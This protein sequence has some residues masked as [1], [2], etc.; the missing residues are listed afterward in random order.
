[1][2]GVTIV[3]VAIGFGLLAWLLLVLSDWLIGEKRQ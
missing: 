3:A 1:M 2:N